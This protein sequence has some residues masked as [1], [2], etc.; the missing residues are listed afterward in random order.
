MESYGKY[1]VHQ[2]HAAGELTLDL[3]YT[4][5]PGTGTDFYYVRVIQKNGQRAWS[6]PIWVDTP[7]A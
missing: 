7:N 1:K 5:A 3:E 2:G 6:S 4:D